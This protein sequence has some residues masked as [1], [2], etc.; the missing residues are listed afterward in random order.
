MRLEE[1]LRLVWRDVFGISGHVEVSR[2]KSKTRQRRLVEICPSLERWLAP[3]R[4]ME[5]NVAK[6][7]QTVN[8][9]VQAFIALRESLG[10]PARR[11][12]LRHGFVT[13]HFALQ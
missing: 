5:G 13:Y 7:W 3:Y 10:I 12:G 2:S 1:V 9:Y 11:N 8:G 6:H 4:S